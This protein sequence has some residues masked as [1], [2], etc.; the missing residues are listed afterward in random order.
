MNEVLLLLCSPFNPK[1]VGELCVHIEPYEG[2]CGVLYVMSGKYVICMSVFVNLHLVKLPF[3]VNTGGSIY[4]ICLMSSR[5]FE[6]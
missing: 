4:V 5:C 1:N 6:L 3:S 2:A